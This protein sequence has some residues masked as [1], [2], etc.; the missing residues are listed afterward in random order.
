[1]RCWLATCP[2]WKMINSYNEPEETDEFPVLK[3]TKPGLESLL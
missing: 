2:Q 1:M 3:I